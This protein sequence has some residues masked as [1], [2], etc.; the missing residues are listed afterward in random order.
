MGVGV[1]VGV[2]V[3]VGAGLGVGVGVGEGLDGGLDGGDVGLGRD[4]GVGDGMVVG[5]SSRL[6]PPVQALNRERATSAIVAITVAAL[7]RTAQ[8]MSRFTER[9]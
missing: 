1:G 9:G 2:A 5:D 3:A 6:S 7:I 4:D 8:E